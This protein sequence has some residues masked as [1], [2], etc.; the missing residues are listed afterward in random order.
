M[1]SRKLPLIFLFLLSYGV[2]NFRHC[3]SRWHLEVQPASDG[4]LEAVDMLDMDDKLNCFL[5][6][7]YIVVIHYNLYIL[8]PL[9]PPIKLLYLVTWE[10]LPFTHL[11]LD[12]MAAIWTDDN[13]KPILFNENYRI[14]IRILLKFVPRSP[15]DNKPTLVQVMACRLTG[16]KPLPELMLTQF[17]DA[18]MRH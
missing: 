12:K 10:R 8:L 7:K 3:V 14:P 13:F 18:Y 6:E 4:N 11:P 9:A 16:D 5:L 15:I 1:I 2:I 17:G